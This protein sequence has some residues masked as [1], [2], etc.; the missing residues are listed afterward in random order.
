MPEK[1]ECKN[2]FFSNI[3]AARSSGSSS[4][5]SVPEYLQE[6]KNKKQL[7]K[8]P[9]EQVLPKIKKKEVPTRKTRDFKL[10]LANK[11][12]AK[13]LEIHNQ[14]PKKLLNFTLTEAS[15]DSESMVL[16]SSAMIRKVIAVGM[17]N[18]TKRVNSK[19]IANSF[20]VASSTNENAEPI[21]TF[22]SKSTFYPTFKGRISGE[23]TPLITKNQR[24]KSG[25][26]QS[27]FSK[28]KFVN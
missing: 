18:R 12:K 13:W 1:E 5:S 19:G 14:S 28:E 22:R 9:K 7:L 2:L 17:I 21:T 8:P 20:M 6:F 10:L 11:D 4:D 3:L 27:L 23:V 16:E 26:T 24:E 15:S 25:F